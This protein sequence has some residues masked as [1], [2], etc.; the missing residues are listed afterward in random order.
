MSSMIA[1]IDVSRNGG[2][3]VAVVAAEEH[4]IKSILVAKCSWLK[5]MLV[6]ANGKVADGLR[7][8]NVINEGKVVSKHLKTLMLLADNLANYFRI[9]LKERLQKLQEEAKR[10]T[11]TK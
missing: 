2:M 6:V 7:D 4:V 11:K 1:A 5:P 10:L 3:V 9:L 8:L